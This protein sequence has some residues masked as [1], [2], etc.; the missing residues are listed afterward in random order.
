MHE[1]STDALA[2][3]VIGAVIAGLWLRDKLR[4]ITAATPSEVDAAERIAPD[5]DFDNEPAAEREESGVWVAA[6][7]WV[8]R[9]IEGEGAGDDELDGVPA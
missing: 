5:C 4:W 6:W 1:L 8:P 2:V 7:V 3:I 9:E